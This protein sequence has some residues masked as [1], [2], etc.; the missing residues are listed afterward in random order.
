[1]HTLPLNERVRAF[2][3]V[4]LCVEGD[5]TRRKAASVNACVHLE[6]NQPRSFIREEKRPFAT[7]IICWAEAPKQVIRKCSQEETECSL[8]LLMNSN[9]IIL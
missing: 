6:I 9:S 7:S 5:P 4:C 8:H 2:M 1:M 3:C